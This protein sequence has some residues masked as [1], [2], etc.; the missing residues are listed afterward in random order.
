MCE[1]ERERE[2]EQDAHRHRYRHIDTDTDTH[3][4]TQTQTHRHTHRDTHTSCGKGIA[5][6]QHDA[7]DLAV[8]RFGP[9]GNQR[10]NRPDNKGACDGTI[11]K[12]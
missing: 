6:N 4:Q 12:V 1:R 5:S 7:S 9:I 2:G 3:T 10:P 11:L 8:Q